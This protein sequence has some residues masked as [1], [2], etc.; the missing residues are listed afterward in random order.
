MSLPAYLASW[1]DFLRFNQQRLSFLLALSGVLSP[2]ALASSPN[3]EIACLRSVR[4]DLV[5]RLARSDPSSGI[6]IGGQ[7]E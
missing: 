1:I 4:D 6:A 3:S 2:D 5:S 7:Y